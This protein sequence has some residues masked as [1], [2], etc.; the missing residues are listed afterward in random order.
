MEALNQE[1]LRIRGLDGA[2][3][4]LK[5]NGSVVARSAVSNWNRASTWRGCRPHGETVAGRP[6]AH[7]EAGDVHEMRWKQLQVAMQK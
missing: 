3:Y 5:I 1:T 2:R 4:T 6:P 7:P